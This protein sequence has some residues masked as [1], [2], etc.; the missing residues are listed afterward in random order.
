[1]ASGVE[2][3]V[4]VGSSNLRSDDEEVVRDRFFDIVLDDPEF[5][6]AEF[7]ALVGGL[8]EVPPTGGHLTDPQSGPSRDVVRGRAGS[9]L[10]PDG[11]SVTVRRGGSARPPPH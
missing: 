2:V 6:D 10:L 1:M 5:L 7:E 8:D 9:P 4:G 3:P 11:R